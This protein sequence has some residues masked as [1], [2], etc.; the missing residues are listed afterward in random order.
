M[1]SD[2]ESEVDYLNFSEVSELT[3]DI[4]NTQEMLPVSIGIF[5]NWGAGKSTILKLIERDL[6]NTEKDSI[7][8]HF[9]A[10]LFQGFDDTRA[11]LLEVITTQLNK[12]AKDNE[13]LLKKTTKLLKRVNYFRMLGLMGESI[14]LANGIPT[15]GLIARGL[16]SIDMFMGFFRDD[17]EISEEDYQAT[18]KTVNEAKDTTDQL[19]KK[20]SRPT[21]PQQIIAFRKEY[22]EV[23]KELNKPLI[24]AIDNLDRCLPGNAIHTLEAVR[25]FLFLPNTAFIIAADEDMIRGSV[26]DYFKGSSTRHQIDYIDKLI[27]VPIRVPKVGT[28]EIRAYLYMLFAVD[29]K[30]SDEKL[31]LLRSEL[32]KA[33]QQSWKEE[34][35]SRADILKVMN[36]TDNDNL[37]NAFELADRIAPI[38]ATSPMIHGNPRIVKRLLNVVKMRQRIARRRNMPI[39]ESIITKL[40]IFERCAGSE[41][42]ADLY[43]L[44]DTDKGKPKIFEKLEDVEDKEQ[45]PKGLPASWT[46]DTI[47]SFIKEWSRI[48]PSLKNKDLRGAVYL[49]RETMPVGMYVMGLSQSGQEVLHTLLKVSSLSSP[50]AKKA[51]ETLSTDEQVPVMEE[52]VNHLRQISDWK[53]RP[54]GFAGAVLLAQ[55]SSQAGGILRRFVISL[56]ETSPWMNSMIKDQ[57]WF[58]AQ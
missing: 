58:K 31:K 39:D 27:Q 49:S 35:T 10:W 15:G 12:A 14:A 1:W 36:E 48:S 25:L 37:V 3:V 41:A 24:I 34:M 33:L 32:E 53:K 18:I 17:D 45:L 6:A 9:D 57:E 46:K 30:L 44:I 2:R 38:L 22:T 55:Q 26:A 16:S 28:R 40:V 43:K 29:H 5:G 19:I 56:G 50:A 52:I 13:S 7:F 20:A 54:D 47:A 8:V 42:T 21:P 11:A 4:M 51:L 23:L